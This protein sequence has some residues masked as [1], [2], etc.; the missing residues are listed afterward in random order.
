[1]KPILF[2]SFCAAALA[3]AVGVFAPASAKAAPDFSCSTAKLIVPWKAGG[4]TAVIFNIFE[5]IINNEIK[6]EPKIQVVTISGQGGNKGAK[7]AK[8]S[9]P[10]GCTLLHDDPDGDPISGATGV[11]RI[12]GMLI[13]G[14]VTDD[15]L[16]LCRAP[17]KTTACAE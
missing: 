11:L 6:A 13:A 10:D 4:G 9:K 7:E 15:G 2:K 16:L 1:M 14:S 17:A 5:N 3:G 12:D 8:S